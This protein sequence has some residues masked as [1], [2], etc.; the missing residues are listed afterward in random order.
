VHYARNGDARIAYRE[1]GEGD[2]SLVFTPGW[3][4][5]LDHLDD[6]IIRWEGSSTASPSR[7]GW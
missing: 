1:F 5:N 7:C 4:S 3:V 6:P 2:N